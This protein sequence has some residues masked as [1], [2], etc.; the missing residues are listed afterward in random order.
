MTDRAGHG[1]TWVPLRDI[2]IPHTG[3]FID[4][5]EFVSASKRPAIKGTLIPPHVDLRCP[6]CGT[7][8][9]LE[10][11]EGEKAGQFPMTFYG[12]CPGCTHALRVI[13]TQDS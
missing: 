4:L 11:G 10:L 12:V 7:D 13:A 2:T 9:H 5:T 8:N 3:R 1:S 6:K